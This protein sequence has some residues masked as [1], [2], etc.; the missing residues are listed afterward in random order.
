[1]TNRHDATTPRASIR[2]VTLIEVLIAVI[3]VAVASMAGVAYVT[4]SSQHS[5]WVRDKVWARQ[6]ALSI[7]S[8]LRAYVQGGEGEV[9]ADL[10]GF[11]DGLGYES[12][13]TITPDP[14]DPGVFVQPDHEVSGN[15][16]DAGDWRWY[17]QITV[18]PFP[19]VDTRDLRICTV[20][21]YRMRS[22]DTHPGERMAEVSS[23]IRTVGDAFPTTQVY[24]LYL[25]AVENVPG[26]WVYMDAIQ[27]FIE[28]TLTDL[29]GR[30]PGLKF[31]THWITTLGY[32]RDEEYAPY[33]NETRDSEANTPWTY[34]YPGTMPSGSSSLHYYVPAEM[35][36][37]V[38][39]DGENT[40]IFVNG[41]A[42]QEAYTDE[43]GNG[44]RDAGE[45]YTDTN[46]NGIWDEGNE[47]PYALADMHNHC[48]RYPDAVAKFNARIAAGI[49]SE[50]S[51]SLRMLLDQMI[52]DP[53]RFH[54]ALF[55]NL[56]G[57]LLPMPPVRNYS[58]AAK[59]PVDHAG[60]RAVTHPER[61]RPRRVQGN[62]A[63]SV[64]PRFRVHAYKT[65]FNGA[66]GAAPLMTQGEPYIDSN[67]NG[68]FDVGEPI[69]DWN[70]NGVWDSAVPI[71]LSV[72]GADFSGSPNAP[73]NPSIIIE[74]LSGGID[75]DGDTTADPY[76]P[77]QNAS[78]YPEQFTDTNSDQI[79]Q[80]A[81][82]YLDLNGN[83]IK[84]GQDPHAERDG[85][86]NFT[87]ATEG[88]IDQDGDNVY[89]SARPAESYVDSNSN[90]TWDPAEP[91][92]DRNGNGMRDGPTNPTPPAWQP[93]NTAF[94]GNT[95][96]EDQYV[97][98]HG[99][100]FQDLD[101]D[102]NWDAAETFFDTNRNGVRDGGYERGEMY[103]VVSY[104]SSAEHTIIELHGTP[105]ETPYV[106]GR[107]LPSGFRLY[108]LE[109][110]P[111]PTPNSNTGSN[112]FERDLYWNGNQPKNTARWRITLPL[113]SIRTQ[114]ESAPG[115]GDGDANDLVVSLDTRIGTDRTT[116]VMWPTRSH[117][118]NLSSTY[119]Y[120]YN[121]VDDV[122]FS[123]RYQFS[124]DP[125]HSPYEDT[126]RTG[127]T[128]VHGYN[129]YF[130]NLSNGS[131]NFQGNWRAFD[132][133]RLRDRWRGRSE[134]DT[135]RLFYWLRTA[136]VR[137][138][139]VWTTLTGFSYY[140]MSIGGDVGYD[141]ANGYPNSIPMDGK[142]FGQSGDLFE[143]S[144][145][146]SGRKFA[147]SNDG[148][149]NGIRSGGYWWAKPWIG[150]LFQDST[151]AAQW[152]TWG[153][154]R[155][156][157]GNSAGEYRMV[158]RGSITG[159]QQPQGTSLQDARS[160]T[161]AEG[162]VSLFNIGTSGSTFH[163]QFRSGQSG[164]L[165]EDGFELSEKY[166]FPLPTTT[167]ISRPFNIAIGYDGGLGDEFNYTDAYPRHSAQ[168][169]RRYYDHN[170]SGLVGSGIVR[171]QEPGANPRGAFIVVNGIDRTTESGS[172]F[173]ARYSML[174]LTHSYFG[175]GVPGGDNRIKQLPRVEIQT[176]T[177]ITELENPSSVP[178]TWSIE[179]RRWDG[180]KYTESYGDGF[181]E[182]ESDLV[183]VLMYSR[184][185][186]ESWL[187]MLDDEEAIPGT[188][189]WITGTGPD[190]AK[191]LQDLTPND[192][193]TF[194]WNTPASSFPEG[195]YMI[196]VEAYRQTESL[197][198][199][200]HM[201]K[202]FVNR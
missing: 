171:L 161:A 3:L 71:T 193:E 114:F 72:R 182:S 142:P 94:Y 55:I 121:D 91:Y 84:D 174:S 98:D 155:A 48:M 135:P 57:E 123:E 169:V 166:N 196:R 37:R 10:D 26:W 151:Y 188:V 163:H 20:K 157:T 99:E 127:T 202:I 36:G 197:H 198:Y 186:G 124:G 102:S 59:D 14:L 9:A 12:S 184:D 179:W 41:W 201:E 128:A 133:G 116:G 140:Y 28:A 199:A 104:D 191:T 165:V 75:A 82:N 173:I 24:D 85:D 138:E 172:S 35:R 34:C 92:W 49:D 158:R 183:Y 86:G 160:I 175:A 56:H 189:P 159:N 145:T 83:G 88:L 180:E 62:D 192:D 58:D 42:P 22:G 65:E 95:T 136:L 51:P 79:R 46:G 97:A 39:L 66:T 101:G 109:Y 162:C 70:G 107:G 47:V 177:L 23:V 164:S 170:S 16:A 105:L 144:I 38:N 110:V 93:W 100:P 25:L 148:G 185:N 130:D 45:P 29:E 111:C 68:S 108:D 18:R 32:G 190:P 178:V 61:I 126:D 5:D 19:G 119:C 13:L 115:A 52:Q 167:L 134:H 11:D 176:P 156:E 15:I 106:S 69:E 149:S 103:F 89:D 194:T 6:K 78:Q 81:E 21:M 31:R 131:G 77:L 60:W 67:G 117:P 54:N 129:W 43:N 73:A 30:N 113:A 7:L 4:R 168:L 112:R 27:P 137:S 147:R 120:F 181:S 80:V 44:Y 90:N 143:N 17:R 141:S 152:A 146:G 8:E 195:S 63:Q 200:Q 50:D 76:L 187:N 150:E 132:G 74:R 33:T 125:R 40:P 53:D 64:A 118:Q 122:P 153:N 139:A 154:L 1:M 87:G 2:G 96:L